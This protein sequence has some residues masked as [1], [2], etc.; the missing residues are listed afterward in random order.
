M[1]SLAA[2]VPRSPEHLDR[3]GV[4]REDVQDH[5]ERGGLARAVGADEAVERAARHLED[6]S[7]TAVCRRRSWSRARDER[8][9]PRLGLARPVEEEVHDVAVA[10]HVVAALDAEAPGGAD[11]GLALELH[12]VVDRV[13]LGADEA[14]LEVA[15]GSRPPPTGPVSPLADRP[16]A[17]LLR[18]GGEEGLQA[19]QVVGLAR[20]G[21]R[22]PSS[23]DAELRLER[24]R[25][26][27]RHH[28]ELALEVAAQGDEVRAG[29]PRRARARPAACG[30]LAPEVV[31]A[32]VGDVEHGLD[33]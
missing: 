7:R 14:L 32:D 23:V 28:D 29:R 21:G 33:A 24:R 12:E 25:G 30:A 18:A 2:R 13:E 22:G 9:G 31:V 11:R 16:G 3:P 26:P 20:S 19:E 5:A 17:D 4:G 10:H 6:S 27:R 1:R 8:R 15:C